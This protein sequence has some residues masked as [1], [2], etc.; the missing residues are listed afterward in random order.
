MKK[1]DW[2]PIPSVSQDLILLLLAFVLGPPAFSQVPDEV[3]IAPGEGV[4]LTTNVPAVASAIA[5]PAGPGIFRRNVDLVLVPVT[6]TDFDNRL[7]NGLGKDNFQLFEGKQPQEIKHFSDEDTPISVGILLDLSGSMVSKIERAREAMVAFCQVANLQDEFFLITFAN[8]VELAEDFTSHFENIQA[9]LL[10]LVPKGRTALLDAVYLGLTH[11]QQA[12]FSRRALFIISDGGD[13]HSQYSEGE[14]K[15]LAREADVAIYSVG[16]FDRYFASAEETA[17]PELLDT[18]AVV[19]GGRSYTVENPNVL[20]AIAAKVSTELRR[21]YV[22][23]YRP[24]NIAPNGKWH[25]IK[26]KLKLP[27][28][29]PPLLVRSKPGYYAR[30]R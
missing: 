14:V 27:R 10:P 1:P 20:P 30:A 2:Y 7:V 11:M 16:M 28:G 22:L 29:L 13:N 15:S 26:I 23:A 9:K 25:R 17:G 21:Q 3:H 19:T 6:I 5:S 12:R 24:R 8:R 4:S 18:M